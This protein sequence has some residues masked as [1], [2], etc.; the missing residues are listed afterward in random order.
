MIVCKACQAD[1][2]PLDSCSVARRKREHAAKVT[3]ARNA[4]VTQ[5]VTPS[6]KVTQQRNAQPIDVTQP[7]TGF[8]L[9][10]VLD[11]MARAESARLGL[12]VADWIGKVFRQ[13]LKP[14]PASNAERQAAYRAR[15]A[16]P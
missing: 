5:P 4:T 13:S 11:A 9:P 14:Q 8:V 15:H 10:P 1:H 6:P 3:D 2:S 12:S 7:V 16:A